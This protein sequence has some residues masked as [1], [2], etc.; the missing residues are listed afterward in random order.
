MIL[1]RLNAQTLNTHPELAAK[2]PKNQIDLTYFRATLEFR[3]RTGLLL[4]AALRVAASTQSYRL[5]KTLVETA[6]MFKIGATSAT[7]KKTVRWFQQAMTKTYGG[8]E[9]VPKIILGTREITTPGE[10]EICAGDALELEVEVDRVHA[11]RFTKHKMEMAV[12]QGVNPRVALGPGMYREGWWILVRAKRIGGEDDGDVS[13][14]EDE[15]GKEQPKS[16]LDVQDEATKKLFQAE[17]E[18]NR[19]LT[20][21]PFMVQNVTQKTGKVKVR[22][23][24]PDKPGKYKFYIDV[25]SQE[26]LGCDES[27]TIE[28]EV[29]DKADVE[30]KQ[31]EEGDDG[32]NGEIQEGEESKKMN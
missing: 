15:N 26:F 10:E 6:A 22:F 23:M 1:G 17:K 11:E 5:Y 31:E 13:E 32:D 9:G 20:A 12:R 4:E 18:E 16:I 24:A 21:W 28:K 30:R 14:G 25:K 3:Q 8:E 19:L 29:L 2:G 7:S 27:F